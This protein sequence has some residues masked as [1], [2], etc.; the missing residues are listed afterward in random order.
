MIQ[1]VISINS[2]ANPFSGG[3][4]KLMTDREYRNELQEIIALTNQAKKRLADLTEE[5]DVDGKR[6]DSLEEAL[7]A[8]YDAVD[9]MED[10]LENEEE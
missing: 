10:A 7:D 1:T 3:T 9:S 8:L 6:A 2:N 5:T 4:G